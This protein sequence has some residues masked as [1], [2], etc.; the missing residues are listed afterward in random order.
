MTDCPFCGRDP[1]HY[2]DIGVGMEA[3]AVTCC[4]FG[5]LYFRGA[6]PAPDE[7]TMSWEEFTDFGAKLADLR[8]AAIS[9]S[10]Q[11][12]YLTGCQLRGPGECQSRG[13]CQSLSCKHAGKTIRPRYM[14][15]P[16]EDGIKY[17]SFAERNLIDRFGPKVET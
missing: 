4:D 14:A 15:E 8:Q 6:R 9:D 12:E 7:V 17:P 10:A 2:V 16:R 13:M 11:P 1:F 3:V 5:D